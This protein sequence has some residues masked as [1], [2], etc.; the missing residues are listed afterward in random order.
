MPINSTADAEI[1]V[2][3]EGQ[4]IPLT[5]LESEMRAVRGDLMALRAD[6]DE[7][8]S[9]L[10]AVQ[11]NGQDLKKD[12]IGVQRQIA[13]L[14]DDLVDLK[15]GLAHLPTTATMVTLIV[16][17]LAAVFALLRFGVVP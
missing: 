12:I 14:S 11:S 3:R 13:G 16:L 5:R 17:T 6:V 15:K 10:R 9:D 4:T 8:T 2:Y 1:D 7:L